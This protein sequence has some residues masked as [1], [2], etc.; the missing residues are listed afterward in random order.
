MRSS[1]PGIVGFATVNTTPDGMLDN[2]GIYPFLVGLSK[3]LVEAGHHVGMVELA[4]IEP[5]QPTAPQILRESFYSAL[6]VHYGLTAPAADVARTLGLPLIWW[7]SGVFEPYGCI[8]RD[9]AAASRELAERLIGLG[10]ERIAYMAGETGWLRYKAGLPVHYSYAQR[11]EAYRAALAA[12][13]LPDRAIV[14]YDPDALAAQLSEFGASAL[15]I[16]GANVSVIHEALGRLGWRIGVNLAVATLDREPR[17]RQGGPVIG[18]MLYDR[19]AA[20]QTAA[21]MV[22]ATLAEPGQPVSSVTLKPQFDLGQTMAPPS[23]TGTGA[24]RARRVP[25]RP[26]AAKAQ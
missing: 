24:G 7:D 8:Y 15:V 3:R 6:V 5:S 9:E 21:E 18:G 13:G 22:L 4:E 23:A 16:Q 20:G 1:K 25:A 2:H 17:I 19:F 10:H 11:Y 14:G 12:H 26:R